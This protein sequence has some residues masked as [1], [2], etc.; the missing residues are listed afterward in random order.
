[1]SG[2]GSPR[3]Q[4]R[5]RS[6]GGRRHA[7]PDTEDRLE[8]AIE[9]AETTATARLDSMMHD[10]ETRFATMME[11]LTLQT[12]RILI[13]QADALKTQAIYDD[14]DTDP[15]LDT[16]SLRS[17]LDAAVSSPLR[18]GG[19]LK[20]PS[21]NITTRTS[22]IPRLTPTATPPVGLHE[23]YLIGA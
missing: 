2:L 1:M 18:P 11:G 21:S 23:D 9:L 14:D 15:P 19:T 7:T 13:S 20:K 8:S 6:L 3:P 4:G 22:K 16:T 10:F 17:E 5:T 12:E